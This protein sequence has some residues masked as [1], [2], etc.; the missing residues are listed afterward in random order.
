MQTLQ[1]MQRELQQ[2]EKIRKE[3][4]Q[5]RLMELVEAIRL[6]KEQ[7]EAQLNRLLTAKQFDGLDAGLVQLRR[8]T[9]AIA[10]KARQ[11][12]RKAEPI[13]E[14]LDEVVGM[15]GG[16]LRAQRRE[17]FLEMGKTPLD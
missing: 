5:R 17:K 6:L 14:A 12:D 7:Q 13:A 3:I 1:Q 8:R 15:E 4:L 11:T 2:A 16:A 9:Q 10:E